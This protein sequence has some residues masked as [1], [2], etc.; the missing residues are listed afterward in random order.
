MTNQARGFVSQFPFVLVSAAVCVTISASPAAAR[1]LWVDRES[2]GGSC[3]DARLA[4]A[5]SRT[6]P[7]CTLGA[8]A[9]LVA[10]GDIVHVRG[11]T[12][13]EVHT[14]ATCDGN[15]VLQL[16]RAGT[17]S[18]WIRFVAE[19][20]ENVILQ[21]G[22]PSVLHGCTDQSLGL[23][24]T[25]VQRGIRLQPAKLQLRLRLAR[26]RSGYQAVEPRGDR[27]R[28]KRRRAGPGAA[29]NARVQPHT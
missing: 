12:Y 6:A 27:L 14:C 24:G 7:L 18:Q 16:V 1:E 20:G 23:G 3:S 2:R 9:N 26:E 17:P 15:A 25:L 13:T 19:P 5:V 4:A 11:G 28:A 10:P 8:A 29:C 21:G 22:G